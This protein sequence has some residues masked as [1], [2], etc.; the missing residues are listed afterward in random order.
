MSELRELEAMKARL[1]EAVGD[2]A[3]GQFSLLARDSP[4]A[5]L[6]L[7]VKGI[8]CRCSTTYPSQL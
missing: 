3:R 1:E 5:T 6:S 4:Y 2:M 7:E 8:L